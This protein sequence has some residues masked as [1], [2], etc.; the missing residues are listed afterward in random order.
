MMKRRVVLLAALA[1]AIAAAIW[2]PGMN[3]YGYCHAEGRFVP[4][5][6]KIDAAVTRVLWAYPPP[7]PIYRIENGQRK[8]VDI[9]SPANP[10]PYANRD[11]F[12]RENPNCCTLTDTEREGQE[13]TLMSRLTGKIS[14]YVTVRYQ[15]KYRNAAGDTI[16]E[17]S[18]TFR[19]I[20]NCGGAY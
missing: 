12:L 5:A 17:P 15:V 6:E 13:V 10:I 18:Q 14:T 16:V 9:R 4:D 3:Y 7:L 2:W 1:A 20:D 8:L 19:A 11:E